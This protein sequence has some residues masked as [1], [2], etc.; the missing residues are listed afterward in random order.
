M[1]SNTCFWSITNFDSA[2]LQQAECQWFHII[3]YTLAMMLKGT[4]E[5]SGLPNTQLWNIS[6]ISICSN[7]KIVSVVYLD[8]QT[9]QVKYCKM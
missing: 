6:F 3:F 4:G 8:G 5:G 1:N 2:V 7:L 9:L